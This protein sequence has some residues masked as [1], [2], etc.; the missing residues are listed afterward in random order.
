[1]RRGASGLIRPSQAVVRALL[2]AFTQQRL[3]AIQY[4]D[5]QGTHSRRTIEAQYLYYSLPAWYVV[6]WDCLRDDIRIF[7]ID[8]ISSATPSKI[9]SGCASPTPSSSPEKPTPAPCD[10]HDQSHSS[11][12]G[13]PSS[14]RLV[15]ERPAI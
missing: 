6:A 7:R 4:Q 9:P 2:Q 14:S 3:A 12:A 8:R 15:A 5:A 10:T 13:Q 1:M 11:R